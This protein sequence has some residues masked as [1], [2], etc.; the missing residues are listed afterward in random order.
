[1][2][3]KQVIL[4]FL[5]IACFSCCIAQQS[6]RER[7][8]SSLESGGSEGQLEDPGLNSPNADISHSGQQILP[9]P[10][11][12]LR[13]VIVWTDEMISIVSV[14]CSAFVAFVAFIIRLSIKIRELRDIGR[15]DD[16][17]CVNLVVACV[18]VFR[19]NIPA[20]RPGIRAIA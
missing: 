4:T 12:D 10:S 14:G 5:S 7:V 20:E 8:E 13:S 1:M 3:S 16:N 19:R 17:V 9:S 6:S 2:L 18:L 11:S 15:I